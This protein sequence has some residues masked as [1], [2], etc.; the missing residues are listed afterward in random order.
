MS[1]FTSFIFSFAVFSTTVTSVH[2]LPITNDHEYLRKRS[3]Y[4]KNTVTMGF[5]IAIGVVLF[6][7]TMFYLGLR[8]GQ[9]GSLLWWRT[10]SKERSQVRKPQPSQPAKP[11]PQFQSI[12]PPKLL[13]TA[14]AISISA[15]VISTPRPLHASSF[16]LVS[17][18]DE[19]FDL[20]FERPQLEKPQQAITAVPIYEETAPAPQIFELS[21]TSLTRPPSIAKPISKC[22]LIRNNY[23]SK[24]IAPTTPKLSRFP[25][26]RA[27]PFSPVSAPPTPGLT[28]KLSFEDWRKEY[29]PSRRGTAP[30]RLTTSTTRHRRRQSSLTWVCPSVLDKEV[31]VAI[32]EVDES[33]SDSI[34]V[35]EEDMMEIHTVL[36]EEETRPSSRSSQATLVTPISP[37]ILS[38][39]S[40]KDLEWPST[41]TSPNFPLP[42]LLRL[43]PAFEGEE[44]EE[45]EEGKEKWDYS[46]ATDV[47][48]DMSAASDFS[49]VS[50]DEEDRDEFEYDANFD[51]DIKAIE[52]GVG[53]DDDAIEIELD[54]ESV[55]GDGPA[56]TSSFSPESN[57]EKEEEKEEE[58]EEDQQENTSSFFPPS[59]THTLS[60]QQRSAS[61]PT[62]PAPDTLQIPRPRSRTYAAAT[63]NEEMDWTGIEWLQTVYAR[64]KSFRSLS[65]GGLS[66][67]SALH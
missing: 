39:A 13:R 49:D 43:R 3:Q 47:D 51:F 60:H 22:E 53:V 44:E 63:D 55:C 10:R 9:T 21:D 26:Y 27:S 31:D 36:E 62:T 19:K 17:P 40:K 35:F 46:S 4:S 11:V 20:R 48:D 57:Q 41:P 1:L 8:R 16:S 56:S 14:T 64:R 54:V 28:R 65:L 61:E 58:E 45:E 30:T 24:R 32:F 50:D 29:A 2:A 38:F 18:I 59:I 23:L 34:T 42:L 52:A 12:K 6:A 66:T 7:I 5:G 37:R 67:N 33:E 25:S 15:S